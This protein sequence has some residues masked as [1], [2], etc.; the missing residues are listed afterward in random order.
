LATNEEQH[1]QH[2]HPPGDA[3]EGAIVPLDPERKPFGLLAEF[4]DVD[5]VL[6]AANNVRKAGFTRWDVFTPFP[7]H[8]MNQAMGLRPTIL[9]MIALIAGVVGAATGIGLQL[10]TMATN[11]EVLPVF[12]QGYPF[13]I[14]GKPFESIPAF[15]PVTFELTVLLAAL[16]AFIGMILLNRLPR[17]YHPAF[18]STRFRRVTT[19][20]F[21]IA[22]E[23]D[24]PIYEHGRTESLLR[25][26]GASDVEQ[27]TD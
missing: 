1:E 21:F 8:G 23:V 3:P 9:P 13:I 20:R 6:H 2:A 15:I 7:V 25:E 11:I 10:Y 17:L 12:L 26:L 27:L 18:R 4:E 14:S 5:T 24:D 19:D 16:A 22:I